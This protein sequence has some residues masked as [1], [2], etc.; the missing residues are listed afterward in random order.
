MARY[1][2]YGKSVSRTE[3]MKQMNKTMRAKGVRAQWRFLKRG[4]PEEMKT[5]MKRVT[6]LNPLREFRTKPDWMKGSRLLE[7]K[8]WLK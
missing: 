1:T 4:T 5:T 7:V 2:L 6:K 3:Y 8:E